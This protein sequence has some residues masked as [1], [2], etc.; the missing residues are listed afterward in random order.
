VVT[1]ERI[2]ETELVLD[3]TWSKT[4]LG[5]GREASIQGAHTFVFNK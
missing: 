2:S 3:L 4:T 5:S 1:L